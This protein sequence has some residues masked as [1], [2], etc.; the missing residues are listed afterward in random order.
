MSDTAASPDK[1]QVLRER[2]T[3]AA[4]SAERVKATVLLAEGLWFSDP[5]TAI[6]LLEQVVAEA[7]AA[8][9]P[10]SGAKAASMLSELL[11]KAGD[12]DGSTRYAEVVLKAADTVSDRRIRA[13]GLNLVGMIHWER[14]EHHRAL[15]C[16]E[17]FLQLSRET[18]FVKGERSALNQLAGI[19]AMQGELDKALACYRQCLESSIRAGDAYDRAVHLHNIGWTLELMGRWNEATEF[20]HRA[21]ALSEEHGFHDPLLAAR[22]ALGELALKRSDHENAALMFRAVVEAER[23]E[24]YSGR[25]FRE[26]LANLGWTYFRSGNLA[27]ASE[28]LDEAARLTEDA[29]DRCVLASIC[30]RRAELD[31]ARGRLGAADELLAQ[32]G[33][34][35]TELNLCKVQG[36]VLRVKAL[37]A[38]AR[39]DPAAA[40]ELLI[41]AETV[42]EPLGDTYELAL[43]R[44]QRGRLLIEIGS[45]D[46]SPALLQKAA[47]TFHRLSVVAEAEEAGRL[48]YRLEVQTD[49]ATALTQGL[50]SL[51]S[52]GLSPE[53]F[54]E[55]ALSILCDNLQ[56]AQGAVL[57]DGH[58]V[59][60][61]GQPDLTGLPKR[62]ALLS[63]TN[64]ALLLPIRQDR[65]LVGLVWL[66]REAPLSARVGAELLDL[67]SRT[68]APSLA[69]MG[70]LKALEA[71]RGPQIPGLRFRGVVGRNPDVLEVLGQIPR[72]AATTVPVLI[73]GESGS[74]KELVARA[75]HE[76]GPRA[77]GT[78]VT[79]N[80][81]AVPES[82]LEAEF[83]GV[84]EGAATG[85][86]ARP[87]KFEQAAGGTIFLDEIGDMSPALQAKLLRVIEDKQITRVG[88]SKETLVDVRIIA[89]TNM[90][91]E[92]RVRQGRFRNDLFYRINGVRLLLPP[93][94]RRREDVPAL[95]D[96]FIVSTA[97]R[98]NCTVRGASKEVLALFA[99][100]AWPGNV[101]Q[102][103]LAVER[104][105]I[106]SAGVALEVTDLPLELRQ[107]QPAPTALSVAGIRDARR[108]AGDEAERA[109][110]VDALSRVNGNASEAA[111]LTG[112]SRAQF[113]RLLHKHRIAESD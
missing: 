52:L 28:T 113:Y 98:H 101:R 86:A 70:E 41:Q 45:S 99:G 72:V 42:L 54:I 107:A 61:R 35:A 82:L 69:K 49:R 71:G 47:Q 60:L 112:Y 29:E 50:L 19:H 58:T 75:L 63:Q 14:G 38:A 16:F 6:P 51:T 11:R 74:G 25:L 81:A 80:C 53:R 13:G 27:R 59:A 9:V 5:P 32:A 68:L 85:V 26:A 48:L 77:D 56:F 1:L 90:D 40:I 18:G 36:E 31:L 64:S 62:R 73:C 20:F 37:L 93:L 8:G 24:E 15:E 89:A 102:L 84:E 110:L 96:Y 43:A 109:A 108:K 10:K 3:S 17:E 67:V 103:R 7:D 46:Q 106:L 105:V 57:V 78:F 44:L 30:C 83:F 88:G 65:R 23:K 76:S 91:L 92:S 100:F 94:R 21:I 39:A 33:R 111:K 95:T 87:G 97:Q 66:R 12:L 22:M 34:H 79:V 104:A 4:T 2:L 55:H